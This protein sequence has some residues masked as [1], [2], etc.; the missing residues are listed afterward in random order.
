MAELT[1]PG[2]GQEPAHLEG[3]SGEGA[4]FSLGR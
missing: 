2:R 3:S 4:P 1:M